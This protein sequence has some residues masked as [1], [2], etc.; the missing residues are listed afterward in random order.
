MNSLP[1]TDF[2]QIPRVPVS[3]LFENPG[4]VSNIG[5]LLRLA[6]AFMVEKLYLNTPERSLNSKRIKAT[7]MGGR[8]WVPVEWIASPRDLILKKKS[9]GCQ[10]VSAEIAEGSIYPQD[11]DRANRPVLLVLGNEV[12]GISQETLQLSDTILEIPT[13][14]MV[15]SLNVTTA[16]AILLFSLVGTEARRIRDR[17][18][19]ARD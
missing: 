8:K 5:V 12:T 11:Y 9:E 4:N 19:K 14:G 10:I 18:E 1:R 17:E 2:E 7:S 6:D 16:A 13:G 3:I 15:R